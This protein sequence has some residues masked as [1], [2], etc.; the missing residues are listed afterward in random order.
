MTTTSEKGVY[1]GVVLASPRDGG[2]CG[3][4]VGEMCED[5]WIGTDKER[6]ARPYVYSLSL[7]HDYGHD[8]YTN[9]IMLFPIEDV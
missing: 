9:N 3:T 6:R 2:K 8:L 1:L 5:G 7:Q 4:D